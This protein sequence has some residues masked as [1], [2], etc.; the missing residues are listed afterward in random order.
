MDF[1]AT[2]L[3]AYLGAAGVFLVPF[4]VSRRTT[5]PTVTSPVDPILGEKDQA[6]I[7]NLDPSFIPMPDY[8]RTR[9]EMVTWMV[10]DLPR[11]TS[12]LHK[13]RME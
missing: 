10:R 5:D 8:L 2:V 9:D 11:L 13:G 7:H 6:A 12:R 4:L 1:T 3:L